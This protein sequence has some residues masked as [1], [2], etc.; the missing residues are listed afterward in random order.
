[1]SSTAGKSARA[2]N[3]PPASKL[4]AIG[5][6]TDS[7]S[8]VEIYK[9]GTRLAKTATANAWGLL[10]GV[11]GYLAGSVW[12]HFERTPMLGRWE[13]FTV[14]YPVAVA[15]YTLFSRSNFGTKRC[16]AF[17]GLMFADGQVTATEYKQIRSNC[18][19]RGGLIGPAE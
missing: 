17:A 7:A 19:R 9:L 3:K 1:M 5:T 12:A 18:L 11:T 13:L 4:D 16:L 10:G 15:V 14:A 6:V 8:L 2:A